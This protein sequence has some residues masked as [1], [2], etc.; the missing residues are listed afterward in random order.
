MKPSK[1]SDFAEFNGLWGT[2]LQAGFQ[3]H[4]YSNR[5]APV[6]R[7]IWRCTLQPEC[8]RLF[9]ILS[10]KQK[11]GKRK[12]RNA[13]PPGTLPAETL[14]KRGVTAKPCQESLGLEGGS[15]WERPEMRRAF[16][17]HWGGSG[18][19]EER[20][21]RTKNNRNTGGNG[22]VGN[23]PV[24]KQSWRL[25]TAASPVPA[26]GQG[27]SSVNKL[28]VALTARKLILTPWKL[29]MTPFYQE[30]KRY[31]SQRDLF[32]IPPFILLCFLGES[33]L[34][35]LTSAAQVKERGKRKRER[36]NSFISCTS[37]LELHLELITPPSSSEPFLT[38][39]Q[40]TLPIR[41]H[42]LSGLRWKHTQRLERGSCA[43]CQWLG[44]FSFWKRQLTHG[45][46]NRELIVKIYPVRVSLRGSEAFPPTWVLPPE[47]WLHFSLS[48]DRSSLRLLGGITRFKK[49]DP[50][51]Q[52]KGPGNVVM[53]MFW[54]E[55]R[56]SSI[57]P[58]F[59]LLTT[60]LPK[61]NRPEILKNSIA[62]GKFAFYKSL[63]PNILLVKTCP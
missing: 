24:N 50:I 49:N 28:A 62:L 41:R 59:C 27:D 13:V 19:G 23:Q 10:L 52:S 51:R 22:L 18:G 47:R 63:S 33:K 16:S 17:S 5:S 2:I 37:G 35:P 31:A 42:R 12:E 56:I 26:P 3:E 8:S 14:G 55:I 36:K 21:T 7:H 44:K 15:G 58:Q 25:E 54:W 57:P 60:F 38:A 1:R 46:V 34:E 4:K 48:E 39:A 32:A 53:F 20:E 43:F 61:R 9:W 40:P 30:Q 45:Q 11:R 6:W 29:Q